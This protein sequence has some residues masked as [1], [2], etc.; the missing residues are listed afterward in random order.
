MDQTTSEGWGQSPFYAPYFDLSYLLTFP[1]W[2]PMRMSQPLSKL[3]A[4]FEHYIKGSRT[5]AVRLN[6]TLRCQYS[7]LQLQECRFNASRYSAL[8]IRRVNQLHKSTN[9]RLL[10][11]GHFAAVVTD[12][13]SNRYIGNPPI[14]SV[15]VIFT[16]T[17]DVG[18]T[19]PSITLFPVRCFKLAM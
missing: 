10:S 4:H 14:L 12:I 2:S 1:Y 16:T 8:P 19:V 15:S 7:N 11:F 9:L 6:G 17:I 13:K 3:C 5:F 18:L